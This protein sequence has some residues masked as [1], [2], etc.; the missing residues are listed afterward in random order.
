MAVHVHEVHLR[1]DTQDPKAQVK[2]EKGVEQA[3]KQHLLNGVRSGKRRRL[4][5]VEHRRH[6]DTRRW[7]LG[8]DP[9]V[10]FLTAV[11]TDPYRQDVQGSVGS[12]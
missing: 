10:D 8:K 12:R 5:E 2:P 1:S 9:G 3:V 11:P 4:V 6:P 7:L